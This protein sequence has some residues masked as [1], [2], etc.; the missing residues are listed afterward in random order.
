M[1]N[2]KRRL[3]VYVKKDDVIFPSATFILFLHQERL[4]RETEQTEMAKQ[5]GKGVGV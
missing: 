4:E 5:S 2:W 1:E 3:L